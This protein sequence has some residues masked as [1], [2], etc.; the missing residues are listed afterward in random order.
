M[1]GNRFKSIQ[2]ILGRRC[3]GDARV[4]DKRQL[5]LGGNRADFLKSRIS[6]IKI[7]N[8]T[9]RLRVLLKETR[10][11]VDRHARGYIGHE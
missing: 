5:W 4:L 8:A 9:L 6:A 3:L 11:H 10:H 1:L 7:L 2:S